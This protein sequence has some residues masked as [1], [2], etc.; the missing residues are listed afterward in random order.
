MD[1][2]RLQIAV[3]LYAFS[4]PNAPNGGYL[5]LAS[6]AQLPKYTSGKTHK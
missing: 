4:P 6:L 2:S 3:D 5:D 1:L